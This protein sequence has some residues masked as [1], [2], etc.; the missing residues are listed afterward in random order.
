MQY[1]LYGY[2]QDLDCPA[3]VIEISLTHILTSI[4]GACF[5]WLATWLLFGYPSFH[6]DSNLVLNE[7]LVPNV[8]ELDIKVDSDSKENTK[9]RRMSVCK[10][11]KQACSGGNIRK[12]DVKGIYDVSNEFDLH[13]PFFL[14]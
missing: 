7:L 13:Y 3:R 9:K 8:S 10:A 2:V 12:D 4:F 1:D 11:W 6:F 14:E 5:E